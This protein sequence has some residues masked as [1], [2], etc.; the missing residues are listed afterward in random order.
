MMI[1]KEEFKKFQQEQSLTTSKIVSLNH[2]MIQDLIDEGYALKDVYEYLVMKNII[3][4]TYSFFC[5]SWK[6]VSKKKKNREQ[7][8]VSTKQ[9]VKKTVVSSTKTQ[10]FEHNSSPSAEL[11]ASL[12]GETDD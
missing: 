1:D 5:R 8:S 10:F 7:V 11:I 12:T 2:K 6:N 9:P 3:S 4:S